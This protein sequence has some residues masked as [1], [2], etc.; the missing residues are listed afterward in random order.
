MEPSTGLVNSVPDGVCPKAPFW[1]LYGTFFEQS[2]LSCVWLN[3]LLYADTMFRLLSIV[4][5]LFAVSSVDAFTAP[6]SAV[7]ISPTARSSS[8]AMFGG[9]A[10][11]APKKAV[12]RASPATAQT[13]LRSQAQASR[14]R[15]PTRHA[16]HRLPPPRHI[17]LTMCSVWPPRVCVCRRR[18]RRRRW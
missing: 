10:S 17:L 14:T 3:L 11:A 2:A 16:L 8:V 15:T 18:L 6:V 12:V 9:K 5:A 13:W 1:T 7:A 4:V